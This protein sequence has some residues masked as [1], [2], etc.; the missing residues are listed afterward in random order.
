MRLP[1][2]WKRWTAIA[3]LVLALDGLKS[4]L[5]ATAHVHKLGATHSEI[6]SVLFVGAWRF[7][8]DADVPGSGG[9]V[10]YWVVPII[11]LVIS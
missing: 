8:L 3:L 5:S 6:R 10:R 4:G 11:G 2:H 1:R 7:T 9:S